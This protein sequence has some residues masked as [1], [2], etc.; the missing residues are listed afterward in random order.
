MTPTNTLIKA[1]GASTSTGPQND[2]NIHPFPAPGQQGSVAFAPIKNL[3]G[4]R[5]AMANGDSASRKSGSY[6][7][8]AS[9]RRAPWI[10]AR[11][12]AKAATTRAAAMN[13][14][15]F[16]KMASDAHTF[17]G[18]NSV[19]FSVL[20]AT[21]GATHLLCEWTP[22]KPSAKEFKNKVGASKYDAAFQQFAPAVAARTG[23]SHG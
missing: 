7:M 19:R 23:D 13:D 2:T 12:R 8:L 17:G 5:G 14:F 11:L 1:A 15:P 20:G 10:D 3:I 6:D 9:G 18:C 22:R 16:T 21:N 4:W